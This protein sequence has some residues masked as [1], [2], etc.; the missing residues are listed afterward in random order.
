LTCGVVFDV[1]GW[2]AGTPVDIAMR[3]GVF[4]VRRSDE[5]AFAL[6]RRRFLH[7]PARFRRWCS[8]GGREAVLVR[9]APGG[10]APAV[11]PVRPG[12]AGVEPDGS[13]VGES[14]ENSATGEGS[15]G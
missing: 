1:L 10:L 3:A 14:V 7:V 9:A 5:G 15:R 6:N 4:V 12:G 2:E 8:F 11:G 13:T